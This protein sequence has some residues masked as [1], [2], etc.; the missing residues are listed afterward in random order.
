MID[1]SVIAII[2]WIAYVVFCSIFVIVNLIKD[3]KEEEKKK[4]LNYKI[5]WTRK[6]KDGTFEVI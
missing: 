2:S 6:M 3:K 4:E 5:D 1:L